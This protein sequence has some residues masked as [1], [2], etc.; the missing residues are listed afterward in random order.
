MQRDE[1][2]VG[3]ALGRH[4]EFTDQSQSVLRVKLDLLPASGKKHRS[5]NLH[6]S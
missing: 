6:V 4:G 2:G 1:R 3:G 5:A